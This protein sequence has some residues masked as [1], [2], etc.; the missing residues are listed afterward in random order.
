MMAFKIVCCE[1]NKEVTL[2]NG[3]IEVGLETMIG[4]YAIM[5]ARVI[6][7]CSECGNEIISK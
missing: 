4:V 1:C 6:I 3:F 2:E 7:E 5:H